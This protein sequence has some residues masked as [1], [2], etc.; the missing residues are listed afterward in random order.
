MFDGLWQD[1]QFGVRMLIK[2]P[3]FT[4]ISVLALAL[5]IGANTAIF[6]VVNAVLLRPLPYKDPDRLVNVFRTQP[7]IMRGPISRPDFLEWQAQQKVFQDIAAYYFETFNLTGIDEAERVVGTRVT[8]NFFSLFGVAPAQGRFFLPADG[9]PG[10]GRVA[11]IGYGIWQ[12]R[13]GADP[14]VV[15]NTIALNGDTYT[16]VGVAP[17]SFNFPGRSEVW[18]PAMLQ[19][20]TRQ[21]GSNYLKVIARLKDGTS[22]EQAQ[23][24]MNQISA[25]LAQ[26]YPENDTNLSVTIAS[27]LEDQVRGIRSVL[28]ILL[29]AVA[30]VLLIACANVANLL[31]ARATSRSK[32]IAVRTALGASRWRIM[33]QLLTESVLLALLGGGL[34]ILLAM[35]GINVLVA[36][37]PS[38]IPRVK[39]VHLDQ[40]VLGFTLLVSVITGIIFGLA[41]AM[42]VSKTNLNEVLKE[43]T[44][45]AATNSPHRAWLR[46][47][48]VVSEIALSLVLLVSAGLLIESIRRLTDVNPGFDPQNLLTANISFPRKA[49]SAEDES[50]EGA[51]RRAQETANFLAAVR[52]RLSSLP[53][54]QAVGAINDL[55]VTGSGS[56]NGDFNI[57]GRPKYKAG[58]APVAEYRLIT[59][60]YFRAIGIPLLKGRVFLEEE[61]PQ[62]PISII[63]NETLAKR[64]FP[65]ED[66][67]GK[68]LLVMDDQ[69]HAIIGVVGDA[70]QWGLDQPPDPEIY[71]S[72]AQIT[73]NP[74]TTLVIRTNVEPASLSE[75]VRRALREVSR[76]AP[77]YAVKT[78]KQVVADSTAQRRFNTILMASFA[79]VALL[80][81]TIGLYGVISYSVA[82]RTQEIGIRMAL[83][84]QAGNVLRMVLWNGFKLALA[85]VVVGLFASLVMTRVLSSLLYGVSATDPFI[86]LGGSVFLAVIALLACYIPARRATKIDPMIALRYE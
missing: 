69:P 3:G 75:S 11:I 38:T 15:G 18:T 8:E 48:L 76:D 40:W 26:Q 13:F 77:V 22:G 6:S 55:P 34:G 65:G 27:L 30:F 46:R 56:V 23:A 31:L 16:V 59:P 78:M 60:D 32:E 2:N 19:E 54:V 41:P 66:P 39:E 20:D 28:L 25:V 57:E 12:R 63:I 43:G 84:A 64:F 61:G 67:I 29:G 4:L 37:A 47:I 33:R 85:G 62:S 50:E 82:Q 70:R 73:F 83:G 14:R 74:G 21:R 80:M 5:G 44:R 72:N 45:G 58:E 81:A 17:P 49:S 35:W 79:A 9:Q 71:F 86:L 42:Q 10:A 52:Q 7:P 53:G 51:A 1:I 68:R 36:F 24:Q